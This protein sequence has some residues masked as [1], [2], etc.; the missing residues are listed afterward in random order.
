M[1]EQEIFKLCANNIRT[2]SA[3]AIQKAK[4]G[5]PGMPLGCADFAFTLFAKYLRHNPNNPEW[6]GRDRFV[7]SAGHGSMLLYSLLHLFNYGITIED[8]QNFRQ[9]GSKTAGHPEYKECPGV[10]IT[11]GPLG[12]G[13]ASSVGMAIGLK[14]CAARSGLD[15]TNLANQKIYVIAGDGCMM[16]GVS[17]EAASLA[18]HLGLDNIICFYDSNRITIEGGTDLAFSEDVGARFSAYNWRVINIENANDIAQC[19]KALAEAQNSDG[20]PTLIIGKTEIGFGSPNKQGKSSSHG[21]PLGVDEVALLKENIGMPSDSFCVLDE[22]REFCNKR[23]AELVADAEKYDAEYKAFAA[24][25]AEGAELIKKLTRQEIPADLKEQ[26]FSVIPADGKDVATR[27]IGGIVLNKAAE[28][29]PA[30]M[31]GAA[32]LAPSTKTYLKNLGDFSKDDRTGRNLHY[33]IR[34]FAMGLSGNG[35]A[36]SGTAIPFCSTFFVFSDFLKP[37]VRL[38]SLMNLKQLFIFTH[39]SFYVGE[40]GPTH[41]PIEHL[42]MFRTIPGVTVFRPAESYE[43]AAAYAAALKNDGPSLIL[44]SRQNLRPYSAEM[45]EKIDAEKGAYIIDTDENIDVLLIAS[46]SEVNLA[47]DVAKELRDMGAGVRVVSM[48]SMEL[49]DKQS[50]EYKDYV[51]PYECQCRV[52]I[53]AG[54]TFGWHKYVGSDGLAFGLDHFGASAPAAVLAEKFGFTVDGVVRAIAQHFINP[55]DLADDC[56]CG[57]DCSSGDCHCGDCH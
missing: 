50:D 26:L 10:D 18:G 9:W 54:S 56:S 37:A 42:A 53:E 36:L 40:D 25:N 41:E 12:T 31:G 1:S 44:L 33:G 5:H 24:A 3:D 48:L 38:A 22:V 20:R 29:I 14:N 43:T 17:S 8:L 13:L 52:S 27:N 7:L 6:L 46:G 32:D 35:L 30:L 2:L 51:L 47:L 49:F 16:E 15:Q 11:T 55:D 21:E 45:A 4:S 34:E 23:V 57:C 19:D 39:D 28:L